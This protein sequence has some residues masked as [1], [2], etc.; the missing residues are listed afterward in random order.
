MRLTRED[1]DRF[2]EDVPRS[3]AYRETCRYILRG[4]VGRELSADEVRRYVRERYDK[5]SS[6]NLALAIFKSLAGYLMKRLPQ[7][8]LKWYVRERQKLE[9]IQDI[10]RERVVRRLEKKG[11]ELEELR[12]VLR[13]C[14][15][16]LRFAVVW[17][18]HWFGCRPI[19]LV[20]L[21]PEQVDFEEGVVRFTGAETKVERE[22]FFDEFT[23][24][25]LRTF[26]EARPSYS[27][28]YKSCRE[29]GIIPKSGRQ[30]FRTHMP[31]RV[32][33]TPPIRVHELV[34]LACGHQTQAM[35]VV[36]SDIRP[37]LKRLADVHYMRELEGEF[38]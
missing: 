29:V 26:L 15:D 4:F 1:L 24:K 34:D 17:L 19:E 23:G 37:H 31:S 28:V 5:A 18:L 33:W 13:R 27:F 38:K 16:P 14:R 12:R 2:L 11:L 35:D 20:S 25:Q 21:R 8:D 3:P 32:S 7:D 10:R 30:S 22:I 36:Y 6:R 9:L